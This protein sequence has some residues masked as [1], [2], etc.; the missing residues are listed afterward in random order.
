[1]LVNAFGI[2]DILFT[3]RHEYAGAILV[4]AYILVLLNRDSC[5]PRGGVRL[6]KLGAIG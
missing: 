6:R 1:V 5:F 4:L 2:F 3:K